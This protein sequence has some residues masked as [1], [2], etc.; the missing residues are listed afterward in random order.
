[1]TEMQINY[2]KYQEDVRHNKATEQQARDELA[3]TKRHSM[4]TESEA[5]RSNL[6]SEAIKRQSNII[7]QSH[8]ERADAINSAHYARIDAETA[9]HNRETEAIQRYQAV[10][11][12]RHNIELE[13]LQQDQL[14]EQTRHNV[15]TENAAAFNNVVNAEGRSAEKDYTVAKTK[16]QYV[17]NQ[18][19][20]A[21]EATNIGDKIVRMATNLVNSSTNIIKVLKIGAEPIGLGRQQLKLLNNRFIVK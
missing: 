4:A 7:N 11:A 21:R 12:A 9:K 17:V 10:E 6:E 19:A 5:I 1:M 2:R 18:F 16:E 15:E 20:P 8:Y 13:S 3:E 14:A